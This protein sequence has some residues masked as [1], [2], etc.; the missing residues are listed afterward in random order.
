MILSR[1]QINLDEEWQRMTF[2]FPW[3]EPIKIFSLWLPEGEYIKHNWQTERKYQEENQENS[4]WHAGESW[5]ISMSK[6][7]ASSN[8][9]VPVLNAWSITNLPK[10]FWTLKLEFFLWWKS[11]GKV[12]IF[13][14]IVVLKFN[15]ILHFVSYS[16][17]V[18]KM[19]PSN[20]RSTLYINVLDIKCMQKI[21]ILHLFSCKNYYTHLMYIFI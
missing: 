2:L 4:E 14:E 6:L 7:R 11:F 18:Y 8:G 16:L 12:F 17:L 1:W 10:F 5:T 20:T 9:V 3:S 19:F 15:F 21:T 13:I